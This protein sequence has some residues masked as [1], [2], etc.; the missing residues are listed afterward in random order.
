VPLPL[1][2]EGHWPRGGGSTSTESDGRSIRR[3]FFL[4]R[5]GPT[6]F[7]GHCRLH[8]PGRLTGGTGPPRAPFWAEKET[9][10]G[11]VGL[12][13]G[14]THGGG[15]FGFLNFGGRGEKKGGKIQ[16]PLAVFPSWFVC[17]VTAERDDGGGNFR[18]KKREGSR[19]RKKN[20]EGS[21]R[22]KNRRPGI[23]PG[24]FF[25]S[26]NAICSSP[27][28]SS[29]GPRTFFSFWGDGF[30]LDLDAVRYPSHGQNS[31]EIRARDFCTGAWKT[32]QPA[33]QKI[34][35]R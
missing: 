35:L 28:W 31:R 10:G 17:C 1:R 7:P 3:N 29:S 20:S 30:F 12:F 22:R 33:W 25:K 19:R 32:P 9:G 27:P 24:R 6:R 2:A 4:P 11:G 15:G 13:K 8:R 21:P 18:K 5:K 23:F 16:P 34:G 14:P 26:P